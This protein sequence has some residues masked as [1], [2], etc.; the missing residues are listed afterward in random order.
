[1]QR[2]GW[3]PQIDFPTLVK[4]MVAADVKDLAQ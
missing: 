1:M 4:E 3:R 2:L